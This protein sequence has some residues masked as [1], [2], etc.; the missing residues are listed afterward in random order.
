MIAIQFGDHPLK[1]GVPPSSQY[2]MNFYQLRDALHGAAQAV[3]VGN[4]APEYEADKSTEVFTAMLTEFDVL[5]ALSFHF[6]IMALDSVQ[7]KIMAD[8]KT[9][10]ELF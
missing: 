1:C 8:L 10:L 4:P 2:H 6:K 7:N 5:L 9:K 3:N